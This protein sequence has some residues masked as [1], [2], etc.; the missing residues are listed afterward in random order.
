M[1]YFSNT[2]FYSFLNLDN[3][4]IFYLYSGSKSS[5][6]SECW[7]RAGGTILDL[8]VLQTPYLCDYSSSFLEILVM[9]DLSK[10][11]S[12]SLDSLTSTL[13]LSYREREGT[14]GK[15][16]IELLSLFIAVRMVVS[17]IMAAL[18]LSFITALIKEAV[19]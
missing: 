2:Y 17:P 7:Y 1:F 16:S 3:A 4:F 10:Q 8:E 15:L 9:G 18:L 13:E 11:L 14:L 6:N 12:S 19:S 5:E